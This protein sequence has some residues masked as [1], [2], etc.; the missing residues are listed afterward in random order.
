MSKI[1][2]IIF[3]FLLVA[4]SGCRHNEESRPFPEG[5]AIYY[6]R[7]VLK[8]SDAERQFIERHEIKR[9]YTRFFDVENKDGKWMP[10]NTLIFSDRVP[11][12]VEI[13]PTVFIDS[14]ALALDED[15]R[16]LAPLILARVDSMM[17]KNGYPQSRELQ[18]DFDWTGSN[19]ERYFSLLRQMRDSLSSKGRRLS[20]TVRLHQLSQAA[21]PADYGV[22]MAYNMGNFRNPKER[23]SIISIA[24]LREYLPGLRSYHL[25]LRAAL[26]LYEWNLLFHE[27]KFVAIARDV[28]L[29]DTT[30]F[31]RIDRN[32]Y[33]VLKYMP[34]P[35]GSSGAS[36]S[37]RLYPGDILRRE[38][39][40][41]AVL[42]S[43][44][45]MIGRERPEMRND[46]ILYH[47]DEKNINSFNDNE[48]NDLYSGD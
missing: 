20:V 43:A 35:V 33:E 46:L 42:D 47:L 9:I 39:S 44:I 1:L 16:S 38:R 5:N 31:L 8:L 29:S 36:P 30:S 19:R 23:N 45:R 11:E 26:P 40:E 41:Y 28:N 7:T 2:T 14:K 32:R 12:E 18:L 13:V 37:G 4:F 21:P 34:L 48:I 17:L 3:A 6:W 22:L 25:P 10:G 27:G 15:V 24:R